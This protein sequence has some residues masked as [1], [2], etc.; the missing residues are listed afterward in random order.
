M[1]FIE[2]LIPF[3]VHGLEA[4]SETDLIPYAYWILDIDSYLSVANC[5]LG[6]AITVRV[7]PEVFCV[8][9]VGLE[10]FTGEKLLL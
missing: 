6:R 3:V 8:S 1:P 7:G 5:I 4:G 2:L 9:L 10:V